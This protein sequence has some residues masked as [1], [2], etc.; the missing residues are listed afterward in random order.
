MTL[1][2]AFDLLQKK[3]AKGDEACSRRLDRTITT[4]QVSYK[5]SYSTL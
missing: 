3:K 5:Y 1:V 4:A 2:P